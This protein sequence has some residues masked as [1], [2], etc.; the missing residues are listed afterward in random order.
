MRN[1][2]PLNVIGLIHQPYARRDTIAA[3]HPGSRE[4]GDQGEL[5]RVGQ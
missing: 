2:V 5:E 4:Y 1:R 3:H